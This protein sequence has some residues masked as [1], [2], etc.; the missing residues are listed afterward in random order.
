LTIEVIAFVLT[1]KGIEKREPLP[2]IRDSR[3]RK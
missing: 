3:D 2:T 1:R